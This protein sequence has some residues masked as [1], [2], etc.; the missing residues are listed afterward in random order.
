MWT[1]WTCQSAHLLWTR[2]QEMNSLSLNWRRNKPMSQAFTHKSFLF[3]FQRPFS[4]FHFPL[5]PPFPWIKD[6]RGHWAGPHLILKRAFFC[7]LAKF[8]HFLWIYF[9]SKSQ[10]FR[11]SLSFKLNS[12]VIP[13]HYAQCTESLPARI[14]PAYDG[15]ESHI[16]RPIRP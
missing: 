8:F 16:S 10:F 14:T 6:K 11:H 2:R 5:S 7:R 3:R 12:V 13:L 15:L 9:V 1:L 4:L